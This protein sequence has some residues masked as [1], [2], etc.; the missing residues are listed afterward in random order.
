M[1][2]LEVEDEDE[3]LK[4]I[5]E[6]FCAEQLDYAASNG[7]SAMAHSDNFTAYS[8][9]AS[10][11]NLTSHKA[12]AYYNDNFSSYSG[13][14]NFQHIQQILYTRVAVAICFF[15]L[16]GNVFNLIILIPKGW[17]FSMGRIEKF[18]NSGLIALAVSDLLFCIAIIPYAFID[19]EQLSFPRYTFT[20]FYVTYSSAIINVFIMASTWLTVTLAVGR[21]LATCHPLRAREVIGMT[22]AKWSIAIVCI[23]CILFNIPRFWQFK[24]CHIECTSGKSIYFRY[25]G[26]LVTNPGISSAFTWTYFVIGILI[27]LVL[28]AFSNTFLIRALRNSRATRRL[29]RAG[30]TT[31]TSHYITMTLVAIVIMYI[32]L[33][34]PAELINFLKRV[35][36][37][38]PEQTYEIYNL[39]VAIVNTL[40]AI[41][42]SFN[43]ILYCL[44]NVSFRRSFVKLL[45]CGHYETTSRQIIRYH[46]SSWSSTHNYRVPVSTMRTTTF[47]SIRLTDI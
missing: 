17:H 36:A 8:D 4:A 19:L 38:S 34:T 7:D 25:D 2:H 41:N 18:A 12:G 35:I 43:F 1:S 16:I 40:Q 37:Q 39:S 32:T 14:H 28:L 46:P 30:D 21:Y 15:G 20:L 9:D 13:E 44:I 5:R 11:F 42:F 3:A 45:S 24:V 23:V 6:T 27:P 47:N 29:I 31:E 22:V 26:Y 10:S 33:V